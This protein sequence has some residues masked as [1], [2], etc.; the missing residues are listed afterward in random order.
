MWIS[1]FIRGYHVVLNLCLYTE[2]RTALCKGN[3]IEIV[4]RFYMIQS[5]TCFHTRKCATQ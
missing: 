5:L 2:I 4:M 3:V 1:S